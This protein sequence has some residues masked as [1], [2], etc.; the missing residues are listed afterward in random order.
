MSRVELLLVKLSN[1]ETRGKAWSVR[2]PDDDRWPSRSIAQ[3]DDDRALVKCNAGCRVDSICAAV[4][5]QILDLMQTDDTLPASSK[6]KVNRKS[7]VGKPRS[8]AANG[9]RNE[10]GLRVNLFGAALQDAGDG[11]SAV[12][13]GAILQIKCWLFWCVMRRVRDNDRRNELEAVE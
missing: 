8:R 4:G 5:P 7:A 13:G 10:A 6:P 11:K 3:G 12:L 2:C 9:Y 1:I